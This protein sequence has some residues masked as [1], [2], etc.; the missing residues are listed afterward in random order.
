MLNYTSNIQIYIVNFNISSVYHVQIFVQSALFENLESSVSFLINIVV[1]E[2][3]M[4]YSQPH[5]M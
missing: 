5:L 1:M 3:K 2:T 4:K